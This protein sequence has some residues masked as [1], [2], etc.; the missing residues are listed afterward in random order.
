MCGAVVEGCRWSSSGRKEREKLLRCRKDA[1]LSVCLMEEGTID[2]TVEQPRVVI[3]GAGMAGLSA[4]NRLLQCGLEN[5]VVLEA[6]DRFTYNH[7]YSVLMFSRFVNV[8]S[9]A[10]FH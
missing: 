3:I 5:F 8:W 7:H 6:S 9:V 10:T 2:P 1:E 4:A